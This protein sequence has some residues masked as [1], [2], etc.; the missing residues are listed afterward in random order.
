VPARWNHRA[1]HRAERGVIL[2]YLRRLGSYSRAPLTH[3]VSHWIAGS[4]W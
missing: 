4:R 3:L 1:L 2:A